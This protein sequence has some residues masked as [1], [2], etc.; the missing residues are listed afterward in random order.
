MENSFF[1]IVWIGL[2]AASIIASVVTSR[3]KEQ[4]K[5]RRLREQRHRMGDIDTDAGQ[6]PEPFNGTEETYPHGEIVP[7]EQ[8]PK[9]KKKR[10]QTHTQTP[11]NVC[12]TTNADGPEDSERHQD[13]A[14][15]LRKAVI[16][17]E[18]LKPKFE[19]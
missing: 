1:D 8:S 9:T 11:T 12:A 6:D 10:Q 2:I 15:D 4:E 13:E 5:M 7:A 17:S 19:D 18:I 3:R 16:Y 14:F